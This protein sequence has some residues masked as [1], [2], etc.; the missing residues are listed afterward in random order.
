MYGF[1]CSLVLLTP[2]DDPAKAAPARLEELAKDKSPKGMVRAWLTAVLRGDAETVKAG[3][4]LTTEEGR[5][6]AQALQAMV[7]G[8]AAMRKLAEVAE[9]KYGEEGVKAAEKALNAKLIRVSEADLEKAVKAGLDDVKI[10]YGEDGQT[11]VAR[12]S[13]SGEKGSHTDLERKR[14]RWFI[15]AQKNTAALEFYGAVTEGLMAAPLE[16]AVELVEKSKSLDEMRKSLEELEKS[17]RPQTE[18]KPEGE[19]K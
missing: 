3:Y 2:P 1:V 8:A 13:D 14:G 5:T 11:A 12:T 16:K 7:R 17:R 10:F 18:Q 4:D 6:T 15:A 19:K 9:R